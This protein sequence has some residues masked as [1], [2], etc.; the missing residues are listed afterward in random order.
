MKQ[1]LLDYLGEHR[2]AVLWK[3]RGVPERD[4]RMPLTP[5]GS[6][7]LG[8]VKHLAA[9][10]AGYFGEC[11]GRPFPEP[12]PW[13]GPDAEVNADMWATAEESPE[14]IVDL[15]R[16]TVAWADESLAG[17]ALDSPAHVAW[18]GRPE[19]TVH[20][21][22]VHML[23]ETARHAG[24]LDILRETVDGGRGLREAMP[25]L[26]DGDEDWWRNYVEKL[27]AVALSVP[28]LD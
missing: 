9:M 6:N 8:L 17:L 25:N 12:M 15:Y 13:A 18:W 20:R 3:V 26:P 22:L 4:L 5:T 28:L 27:R 24:H 7:L 23:A 11:L 16:R 21:L 2:R 19:T 10:E 14:Q 1:T